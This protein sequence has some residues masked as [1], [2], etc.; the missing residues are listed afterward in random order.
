LLEKGEA[1]VVTNVGGQAM[2]EH[3]K[4]ISQRIEQGHH[5][6]IIMDQAAWHKVAQIPDNLSIIYL[7]AYS[8]ELNPIENVWHYLKSHYIS[9]RIFFN[10][11]DIINACCHAWNL[12]CEKGELI[13][14]VAGCKYAIIN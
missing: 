12:F 3:L 7:P 9:N 4:A 5:G 1:I 14:T 13:K 8:P 11:E 6:V 2:T 10:L